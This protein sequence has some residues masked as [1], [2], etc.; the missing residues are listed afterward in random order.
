MGVCH[1]SNVTFFQ[2]HHLVL[3]LF[4]H[5][6]QVSGS[7]GLMKLNKRRQSQAL[8]AAGATGS[9]AQYNDTSL[10]VAFISQQQLHSFNRPYQAS[11][12][13]YCFNNHICVVTGLFFFFLYSYNSSIR[14]RR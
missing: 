7:G 10:Q 3:L 12:P 11:T 9:R 6:S 1:I 14:L 2:S 8:K 13:S 5:Q 4:L